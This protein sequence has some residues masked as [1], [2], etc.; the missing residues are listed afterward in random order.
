MILNVDVGLEMGVMV[1]PVVAQAADALTLRL[2][3]VTASPVD[4]APRAFSY[5]VLR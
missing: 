1:Q 3:N 2:C 5:I 4:P